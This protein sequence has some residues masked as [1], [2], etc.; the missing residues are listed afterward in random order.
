VNFVTAH[1]G[2]TLADL[3]SY[4]HKH[5]EANG[6]ANRDGESFARS[7][8]NGVEGPTDDP[9]VL[10][11]R[12][13][14][15]RSVLAT[16]LLSQGVPMLLGGDELGRTQLG[17]NNAYCQDNEI[18]WYD[19]ETADLDLLDFTRRL[20]HLRRAHPV[21]HRRRWFE[22]GTSAEPGP[23]DI[24][25]FAADGSPMTSSRWEGSSGN[26]V[27]VLLSAEGLVGDDGQ[28]IADD[29]FF[30]AFNATG[31]DVPFRLPDATPGSGW[32]LTIDTALTPSFPAEPEPR[33][34]SAPFV[35]GAFGVVVLR[36]VG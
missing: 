28:P 13:R 27:G 19:W 34:G 11:R 8:N 24:A 7:W 33:L 30:V 14:Q 36:R 35:V 32:A 23:L 25:W 21:F 16:L 6:D 1:D 20:V 10:E 29:T 9:A 12:A 4:E 17:N 22:G 31:S 3:V 18:S 26:V 15:Q 5:N 2:F